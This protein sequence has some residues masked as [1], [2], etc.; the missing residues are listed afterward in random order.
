MAE[1]IDPAHIDRILLDRLQDDFPLESRPFLQIANEFNLNE[2]EVISRVRRLINDGY[3]RSIGPVF[4]NKKLGRFTALVAAKVP[5]EKIMETA[6]IVNSY[7]EVTHNYERDHDFNL[8]FTLNTENRAR[9]D[10]VI[11]EIKEKTGIH[12]IYILPSLKTFK[13]RVKFNMQTE[14]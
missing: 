5:G 8:W 13:L 4:D 12:E 14:N 9:A 1:K 6:T 3:I 7:P 2:H 10:R 11:S